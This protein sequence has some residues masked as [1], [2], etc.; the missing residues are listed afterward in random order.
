MNLS[1]H[2]QSYRAQVH[3]DALPGYIEFASNQEL[4]DVSQFPNAVEYI[5]HINNLING[6][7][8]SDIVDMYVELLTQHRDVMLKIF[9]MMFNEEIE[10]TK[11]S[12]RELAAMDLALKYGW[13]CLKFTNMVLTF[14]NFVVVPRYTPQFKEQIYGSLPCFNADEMALVMEGEPPDET[15]IQA[16]LNEKARTKAYVTSA[17]PLYMT[18]FKYRNNQVVND[19]TGR[20]YE[21]G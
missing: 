13:R 12:F 15:V 9:T 21:K 3:R 17:R 18:K 2:Y 19:W 4:A 10:R 5:K 16:T 7:I 14:D 11:T 8:Q 6:A 20:L 1:E